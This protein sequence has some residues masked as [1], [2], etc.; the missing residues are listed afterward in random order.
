ML[1]MN[2]MVAFLA[3]ALAATWSLVGC[4]TAKTHTGPAPAQSGTVA[5]RKTISFDQLD[6]GKTPPGFTAALTGGGGPVSWIVQE[7]STAP[8]GKRVLAQ[9]SSDATDYRFPLCLYDGITA[10]DVEV[11]VQFKS[12]SGKVDQAAGVIVRCKDRN[13]YYVVRANALEDNVRLY[14][15]V[16][17]RRSEIA[18]INTKVSP[19]QWH[20]LKLTAKGTHFVVAFGDKWFEADDGTFQDPGKA[21]LWTK[22]DS[23]TYFDDLK[24]ENYD[25][26]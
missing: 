10:K 19:G 7:D 6:L 20:G 11:S 18:G 17:G 26:R 9:T 14:K 25:G 13:N 21:G 24:I 5:V 23:V 15:V 12:V 4:D 22:A 8:S 1:S 16:G 2:R 3:L